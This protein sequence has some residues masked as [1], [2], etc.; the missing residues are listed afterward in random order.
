MERI[1]GTKSENKILR[2]LF[3]SAEV[4][5]T[6]SDLSKALGPIIDLM[7]V[8]QFIGVEGVTVLGY[9]SPLIML[10]EMT[11]TML[12]SGARNKVSSL[13]GASRLEEAN[14]AFSGSLILGGGL[15]V[16]LVVF[17]ALFCPQV[18]LI[19]GA[20][21]PVLQE[22]TRSYLLGYLVG[23]PFFTLSRILTPYLQMEGKYKRVNAASILTTV[24]DVAVDAVV[25]FLLRGGMF[26]IGLATSLGY[27]IPFFLNAAWFF[28]KKSHSVF[29]FSFRGVRSRLCLEMLRLGAPAGVVKSANALG[30]VLINNLLTSV[31]TPYLVA[32]YGVFSQITVFVRS[33]WYAPADTLHAFSGVFIGEEDRRSLK[34]IQKTAVLHAM[35]Y[36]GAVSVLIFLLSE[37]L[38][39]LFLKSDA[40]EALRISIQCLRVACWS[41]PFHSIVYNFNNY[42]MSVR[43]VRF[44]NLYSFLIECGILVPVTY[45]LLRLMGPAGA[46]TGKVVS[47]A[48][49]SLLAV[50]YIRCNREGDSFR[51]RMLLLPRSFGVDPADEIAIAASSTE[52]IL[53]LSRIAISFALEH[54]ADKKRAKTFGLI[55]EELAGIFSAHGFD[56]GNT[57]HVNARLVAKNGELIIRMRDDCKSFNLVEYDRTAH[58]NREKEPGLAVIMKMSKEV[59]YT[60]TFGANNLIVRV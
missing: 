11:G 27:I 38:A 15:S 42:L 57:H 35:L 23:L 24:I 40:P 30:G 50:L 34:E 5:Y 39:R 4:S 60:A 31:H 26:E 9:V 48:V 37:P 12:T 18:C 56:D 32:A 2:G 43:R 16:L 53:M 54:H 41:L 17:T 14:Q 46:W 21:D 3:R 28:L 58:H 51:D 36:T 1:D 10:F 45:L 13:L 22:M 19:L 25:I 29:H 47:M 52:E 44:C 6:V 7:F 49:L 55:T 20:R 8:S 33:S 59:Q